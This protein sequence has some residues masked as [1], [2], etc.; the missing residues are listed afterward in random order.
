MNTG[1]AFIFMIVYKCDLNLIPLFRKQIVALF[2]KAK[3]CIVSDRR[4]SHDI[5]EKRG[6]IGGVQKNPQKTQ[7]LSC[8][9][10]LQI[11]A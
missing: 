3:K 10:D 1:L 8:G 4:D 9:T 7:K 11:F 2:F 6:K 5:R